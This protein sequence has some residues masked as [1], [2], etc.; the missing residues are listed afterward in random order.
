MAT[1]Q[2]VNNG[3]TQLTA[4]IDNQLTTTTLNVLSSGSFPSPPF[5][6]RIDNELMMVTAVS[7][8]TWTVTRAIEGTT[9]AAHSSG[10]TVTQVLTAAVMNA[11][12]PLIATQT[13]NTVQAG[14]ASGS[15]A[16]PAFR[17]LVSA[18]LPNGGVTYAKIQNMSTAALL[19]G[20]GSAG[21]GPPQEISLGSGLSMS[22]TTL[23]ATGAGGGVT[24]V[25]VSGGTTGLT[26]S[27]GPITSSG[28]ITLGGT[29]AVASG[30]T[31]ATTAAGA[32][33]NLGL[34]TAAVQNI[35]TSGATVP[36]LNAA[37]TWSTAQ[38]FP[39][40]SGIEIRD[41]SAAY[42][43]GLVIGSTLTANRTLT[44]TTGDASRTLTLTGNAS[45]SGTNTGDQTITLT[46]DVTGSGTGSFAA[47]I[48][49]GAVTY[50]KMQATSAA[51]VLLGRG[52]ASGAGSVQEIGLGSGLAM[53]GT[54]LSATA[55]GVPTGALMAFAGTSAP[56]G[57]LGCDGSAVSRTT[58]ASLFSVIGTTWGAGDG[59]T[60]FNVPNFQ[61][62][63]A[64]GS[65]GTGTGTLGS[66]VGNTGGEET[67]TLTTAEM[68]S[69]SHGSPNGH[70]DQAF[71][72]WSGCQMNQSVYDY[73]TPTSATGGGVPHNNLQPSAVVLMC[74]KT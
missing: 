3:V 41:V 24:S 36:L 73:A 67:H 34:G 63:V 65:G 50:T 12:T 74:V 45:I 55:A 19:L 59:A 17:A 22:G 46:G 23:S 69:H 64:V 5:R 16:V 2:L 72:S 60:T 8:T 68:P 21:A 62:R 58:Y 26:T 28:T 29:L 27:G 11:L 15:P 1:E 42:T 30:G 71:A 35:G 33:A 20:T 52:S 25:G 66:A 61:R 10:A 56:S 9:A 39:N 40:S 6:I 31:G 48:G 7:G 37:N 53:S 38:I 14:P 51:S 54:T 44:V 13:A 70:D 32:Q 57:W 43:V 4:A 18:D 49:T 47:T